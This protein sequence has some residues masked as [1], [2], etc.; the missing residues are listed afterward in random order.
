LTELPRL[1][2]VSSPRL[3]R[4]DSAADVAFYLAVLWAVWAVRPQIVTEYAWGIGLLLVLEVACQ[5]VSLARSGRPPATHAYSAKAWGLCL[6]AAFV[7]VLGFGAA[8]GWMEV[9]I[10]VGC[11]ANLEVI[12]IMLVAPP[13][14]VD[15]PTVLHAAR[16]RRRAGRSET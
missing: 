5:A 15:V 4:Y 14:A 8:A 1:I 7:A 12:A 2:G 3:R 13:P 11:L 10:A 9:M 6:F 16:L